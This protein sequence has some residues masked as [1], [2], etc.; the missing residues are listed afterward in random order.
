[1]SGHMMWYATVELAGVFAVLRGCGWSVVIMGRGTPFNRLQEGSRLLMTFEE[2]EA[3]REAFGLP[4]VL[5]EPMAPARRY[6]A[7]LTW[8]HSMVPQ[9][10]RIEE[11]P[12]GVLQAIAEWQMAG[13]CPLAERE[14]DDVHASDEA[15][16]R[17]VGAAD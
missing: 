5:E 3:G 4:R 11:A 12:D 9:G 17:P 2:R 13:N 14:A 6:P 1:M 7:S 15:A 16:V 10:H 8:D